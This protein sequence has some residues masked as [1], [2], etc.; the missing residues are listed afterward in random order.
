MFF[1]S[2]LFEGVFLACW[3]VRAGSVLSHRACYAS[4]AFPFQC[5]VRT[6]TLSLRAP[7]AVQAHVRRSREV[8]LFSI[9]SAFGD[10]ML[11][12]SKAYLCLLPSVKPA[13]QFRMSPCLLQAEPASSTLQVP[14]TLEWRL[15][16]CSTRGCFSLN[17]R[18]CKARTA[19]RS[20]TTKE[21]SILKRRRGKSRGST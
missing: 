21:A 13:Q 14:I 18:P 2:R 1:F 4:S 15:G 20:S 16:L 9:V 11:L 17:D 8:R 7:L 6:F 3:H 10:S 19:G 12:A 5:V